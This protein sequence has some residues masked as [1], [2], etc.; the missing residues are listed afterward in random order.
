[1][2]V[3]YGFTGPVDL[4]PGGHAVVL[5]SW[6]QGL[7]G[8]RR[9]LELRDTL[10]VLGALGP[11]R[12][13]FLFRAGLEGT[14]AETVLKYGT[15]AL[16][17]D[18]CRVGTSK[19]VPGGLSRTPGQSLSGSVDGS[20]RRETGEEGGHNPN[21]GRWPTN[22]VFVHGTGCRRDG[23]RTIKAISGG[24]S[25]TRNSRDLAES[26]W[27]GH[28]RVQKQPER[29]GQGD[30]SGNETV[31]NWN[32][33]STCPVKA[34]D[35]QSGNLEPSGTARLGKLETR[36]SSGYGGYGGNSARQLPNDS[37]GASRF[38]PQFENEESMLT[39]LKTLIGEVS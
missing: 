27:W 5:G 28:G 25:V 38:F 16:D 32:C 36:A 20:L 33:T 11:P 22:L 35:D 30:D 24:S 26:D 37:G 6:E 9:G 8:R 31:P 12:F 39:W 19:R 3:L 1:M 13:A 17:I 23:E 7:E 21:V 14:V 18:A 2:P 4:L 10:L 34:L 29:K 15:G